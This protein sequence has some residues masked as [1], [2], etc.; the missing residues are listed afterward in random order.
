MLKALNLVIAGFVCWQMLLYTSFSFD[1]FDILVNLLDRMQPLNY[2]AGWL[3]TSLPVADQLLLTLMKLRL[4]CR[5]LDSAK[6]FAISRTTV[7]NI[8]I[9]FISALHEIL[10][11]G[12]MAVG[13]P[14]QR[15]CRGSMPKS[16]DDFPSARVAMDC[17]EVTQDI[18]ADMNKQCLAHSHYKSRHTMK[19][20]TC[21]APS[22]ALVYCCD[23]YPGSTSD[24]NIVEHSKILEQFEAG[25]LILADK[26]FTIYD[27][28]PTG[29]S[30]N[31]PPFLVGKKHFTK[32][33][34]ETCY[35]IGRSRI[36]VERA[37]ARIKKLRHSEPY[38]CQIQ[39]AA[40]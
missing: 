27:K 28:L 40:K 36:H 31:I 18:P 14:S 19:A 13:I 7:S 25:D 16:F 4:N 39:V 22:G 3:V 2:Y 5:D 35:K 24:N 15:K 23:L 17:T 30:L 34:A 6:R 8:I 10:F 33:E 32:A 26:G 21:V 38:P 29:V 1:I 20:L 12:V 9:T 11:D 37:N